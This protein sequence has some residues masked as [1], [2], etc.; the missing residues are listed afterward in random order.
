M[1]FRIY[2]VLCALQRFYHTYENLFANKKKVIAKLAQHLR[3]VFPA[4]I[5]IKNTVLCRILFFV[6]D[7]YSEQENKKQISDTCSKRVN[8]AERG[9]QECRL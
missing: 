9:E 3:W 4:T 7:L 1:L 5:F 2:P 8:N 6:A